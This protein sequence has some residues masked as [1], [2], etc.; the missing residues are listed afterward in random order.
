M[1]NMLNNPIIDSQI[2]QTQWIKIQLVFNPKDYYMVAFT[3]IYNNNSHKLLWQMSIYNIHEK[4]RASSN[5][6]KHNLQRHPKENKQNLPSHN[7]I[8]WT[9]KI[10]SCNIEYRHWYTW[11]LAVNHHLKK[12][13]IWYRLLIMFTLELRRGLSL[14]KN[15]SSD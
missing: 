5:I 2:I 14:Y 3:E 7:I 4:K 9:R 8:F 1:K 11:K 15:F 6:Y 13:R 12:L 10:V